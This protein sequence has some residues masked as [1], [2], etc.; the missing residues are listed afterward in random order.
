MAKDV[1]F[2]SLYIKRCQKILL[3]FRC[4]FLIILQVIGW[5]WVFFFFFAL[6]HPLSFFLSLSPFLSFWGISLSITLPRLI[7]W[8]ACD[9]QSTLVMLVG[10]F[11]ILPWKYY[12]S[13]NKR[14]LQS[15]KR[16]ASPRFEFREKRLMAPGVHL[17]K[18]SRGKLLT[19]VLP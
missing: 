17:C 1:T 10:F 5:I 16:S 4:Q 12:K 7:E 9:Y 15:R 19:A 2:F 3:N 11:L 8:K 6:S 14:K 13:W 18:L